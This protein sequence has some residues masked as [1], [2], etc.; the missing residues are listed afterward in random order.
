MQN[1]L[2]G[3]GSALLQVLDF[4]SNNFTGNLSVLEGM[5]LATEFRFDQNFLTG[6]MPLISHN[7]QVSLLLHLAAQSPITASTATG[8]CRFMSQAL[9]SRFALPLAAR[10]I[11]DFVKMALALH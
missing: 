3:V 6:S 8:I 11:A 5:S 9:P 4:G 7:V 2:P 10:G 1:D